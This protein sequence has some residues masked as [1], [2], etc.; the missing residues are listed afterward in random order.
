MSAEAGDY[1]T[2]ARRWCHERNVSWASMEP[3]SSTKLD[4]FFEMLIDMGLDDIDELR[5]EDYSCRVIVLALKKLDMYRTISPSA[6]NARMIKGFT[7]EEWAE[8][9][10]LLQIP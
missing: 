9:K 3:S 6:W 1:L 10:R 5:A 7:A 8:F 4:K 2:D